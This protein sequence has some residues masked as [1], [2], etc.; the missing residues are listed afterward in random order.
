MR[1]LKTRL[2]VLFISLLVL[3][4]CTQQVEQP[5][6]IGI[7][8][9]PGYEFLYLA[10]KKG[11]FKEVGANIKIS[12]LSSLANAQR[13]YVNGHID[14]LAS[15]IIETVQAEVLGG[16]PLKIILVPDYSNGG[17]VILAHKSVK[18]I[19]G[20]KGKTVGCEVS[21]L[22][23]YVLQRALVKHSLSLSDIKIVNI[24]QSDGEQAMLSRKIDAYVSYPPVSIAIAK[25][26][27]FKKIFSSADIP[28][29][30]ID[31]ISLSVK[32]LQSHPGIV[33]KIR[34]AWQMALDYAEQNP[35]DANKIMAEREG[36][37]P[38][39]FKDVLSD[40]IVLNNKQQQELF[41]N[42]DI[43]RN[44]TLSVCKTLTHVNSI[45]TNCDQ[46][47][48]LVYREK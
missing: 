39:E 38:D 7:N 25:H 15:T 17:D 14:G 43:L 19:A 10:E 36:V 18:D 23:I 30:I 21:S 16:S 32:V 12:Q 48:D 31:T 40:L 11:F 8:P 27:Q 45:E 1:Y 3:N 47:P 13:A 4:G 33:K 35:E 44:A 26:K 2:L 46:L 41:A 29:E 20:L 34:K 9:W 28:K 6:T 5:V 42:P 22:G 37:T 24:E